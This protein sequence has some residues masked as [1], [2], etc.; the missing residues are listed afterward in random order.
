MGNGPLEDVFPTQNGDFPAIHVSFFASADVCS[1][2]NPRA[3]GRA[4]FGI[5]VGFPG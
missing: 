5:F 4:P 1:F 3:F 2:L